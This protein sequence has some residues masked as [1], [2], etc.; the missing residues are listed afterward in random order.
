MLK[1]VSGGAYLRSLV[2]AQHNFEETSQ[3]WRAV[4]ETE[5]DL[6]KPGFEP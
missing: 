2:R 4:R 6:S 1:D 5:S 3:R